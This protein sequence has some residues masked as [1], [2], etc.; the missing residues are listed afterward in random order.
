MIKRILMTAGLVLGAATVWAQSLTPAEQGLLGVWIDTAGYEDRMEFFEDHTGRDQHGSSFEWKLFSDNRLKVVQPV[1]GG[2]Q[3]KTSDPLDLVDGY[4]SYDGKEFIR[5]VPE[6]QAV[7][8]ELK[9]AA[10]ILDDGRKKLANAA[11]TFK[12]TPQTYVFRNNDLKHLAASGNPVTDCSSNTGTAIR[13]F[14]NDARAWLM[15]ADCLE[16]TARYLDQRSKALVEFPGTEGQDYSLHSDRERLERSQ[17]SQEGLGKHPWDRDRA[18]GKIEAR[19]DREYRA[20]LEKEIAEA[21][22]AIQKDRDE[23][24]SRGAA[25]RADLA[26]Q[27]TEVLKRRVEAFGQALANPLPKYR[28]AATWNTLAW[29]HA[30]TGEP[31]LS[32]GPRALE[33]AG[34]AVALAPDSPQYQATLAA[35]AARAG[36]FTQAVRVEQQVIDRLRPDQEQERAGQQ[37]RLELY[38]QGKALTEPD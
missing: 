11:A 5:Y 16:N 24:D 18:R 32:D 22:A 26:K 27:R 38:Q 30:T 15:Q 2:I 29:I 28:Q 13:W 20:Y 34:K 37:R 9:R 6:R 36:D 25:I 33:C 14:P 19:K 35:A 1:F 3:T 21:Q 10:D 8:D 23:M 31:T 4:F 17:R 12:S 7:Y